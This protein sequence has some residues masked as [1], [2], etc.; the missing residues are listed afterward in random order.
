VEPAGE[1][2]VR[3][4]DCYKKG[5]RPHDAAT[6]YGNA[7]HCYKKTNVEGTYCV[8]SLDRR[9]VGGAKN[10]GIPIRLRRLS[11]LVPALFFARNQ[12]LYPTN[13]VLFIMV[14]RP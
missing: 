2:Y 1:A 14:Q 10:V 12:Q 6:A 3:A 5:K 8:L 4:G 7:S 13:K 11:F 9:P